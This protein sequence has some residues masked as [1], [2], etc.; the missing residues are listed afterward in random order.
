[1]TIVEI[2]TALFAAIWALVFAAGENIKD[3]IGL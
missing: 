1:M 2:L 3:L